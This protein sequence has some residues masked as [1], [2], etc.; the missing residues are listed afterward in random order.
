MQNDN[1]WKSD[2]R[3]VNAFILFL[4]LVQLNIIL[5]IIEIPDKEI[6]FPNTNET[7]Q[8]LEGK[9]R[10]FV[11]WESCYHGRCLMGTR[12]TR[13]K[14]L[15][16]VSSTSTNQKKTIKKMIVFFSANRTNS[17]YFLCQKWYNN[18]IEIKVKTL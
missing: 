6:T 18:L 8:A 5:P 17:I 15:L 11:T 14:N 7:L 2:R 1:I 3:L 16:A 12:K 4:I 10:L 13:P 9:I